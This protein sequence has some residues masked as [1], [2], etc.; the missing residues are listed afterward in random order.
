MFGIHP[1][2][3]SFQAYYYYVKYLFYSQNPDESE[4]PDNIIALLRLQRPIEEV[5][6]FLPLCEARLRQGD[7]IGVSGFG[8]IS[9]TQ[10][11]PPL[12]VLPEAI[13][14]VNYLQKDFVFVIDPLHFCDQRDICT[15]K[16]GDGSTC[17]GDTGSPVYQFDCTLDQNGNQMRQPKCIYGMVKPKNA[18]RDEVSGEFIGCKGEET[19]INITNLLPWIN[20]LKEKHEQ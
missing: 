6:R 14:S 5:D 7:L 12:N 18:N 10:L 9:R 4:A 20:Q 13:F 11:T 8:S 1:V 17:I 15:D 3:G 2:D 16:I 19:F